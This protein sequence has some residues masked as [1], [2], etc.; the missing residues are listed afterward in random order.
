VLLAEA[1]YAL[2]I[3]TIISSSRNYLQVLFTLCI[4]SFFF[5]H[6][7]VYLS[8]IFLNLHL[9]LLDK[10]ISLQ[11]VFNL[12]ILFQ[13][14]ISRSVSSQSVSSQSISSQSVFSQP[15]VSQSPVS[16]SLI[17]QSVSDQSVSI[18]SNSDQSVFHQSNFSQSVLSQSQSPAS[19]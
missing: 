5:L 1:Q 17:N 18:L 9:F 2:Q 8:V 13:S 6:L 15:S 4:L 19:T 10:Q 3:L 11:L 14:A 7:G 12:S 16:Q